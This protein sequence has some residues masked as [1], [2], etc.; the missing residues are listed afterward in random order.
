MRNVIVG[1]A[2]L[3]LGATAVHLEQSRETAPASQLEIS[4]GRVT[5]ETCTRVEG[6]SLGALPLEV[7][8]GGKTVRFSEWTTADELATDLVGF[9]TQLPAD[10]TFTVEAGE[11]TFRSASP[12]WL[13]PLG[14]TGPRVHTI[15][16]VT[17][18]T[19]A[20]QPAMAR[21]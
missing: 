18:C 3:A 14:I 7:E 16:A 19:N 8:V 13:N 20:S 1:A 21:R 6:K 9:A 12:R 4:V 11:R 15:D 17:F 5:A 10:V 2:V